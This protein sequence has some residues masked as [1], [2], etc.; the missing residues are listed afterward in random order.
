M[1]A[2]FMNINS[3]NSE[4]SKLHILILDL[5]DKID[6]WRGENSIFLINMN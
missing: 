3:D 2:I 4:T 5:I 1:D 6:L